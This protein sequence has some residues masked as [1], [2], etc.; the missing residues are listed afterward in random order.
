[1]LSVDEHLWCLETSEDELAWLVLPGESMFSVNGIQR[2]SVRSPPRYLRTP[3]DVVTSSFE[4]TAL[5]L[6]SVRI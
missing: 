4:G 6:L 3:E 2:W 5:V 1:M